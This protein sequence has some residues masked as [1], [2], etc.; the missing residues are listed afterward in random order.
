MRVA[1]FN[2][3]H[4]R[5]LT[6]DRVDPGRL[7]DAVRSLD[8]DVL[9]LQEVDRD[10]E[11]S[12]RADLTAVAA[13]A[14]GAVDYRFVA[15]LSGTPGATWTAAT[16]AEQPEQALYGVALLSRRRVH[17]WQVVRL[18]AAPGRI[19]YRFHGQRW[20][21]LVSDEPRV[22]V[23]AVLD[24]ADGPL[25]VATTH[26]SY[27]PGW[28]LVQLRR[29]RAALSA[30]GGPRILTGDLNMGP[31]PAQRV[32]GMRSAGTA[33]TFPGEAPTRQIDHVLLK[34]LPGATRVEARAMGLSDHQAL[35]V[36]LRPDPR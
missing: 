14:M 9:G 15:A 26:L 8:A 35:V 10:Q 34:G 1:T 33:L 16:G 31:G 19:P 28:N 17:S 18:P 6:D 27:L 13:Q 21:V 2:I 25:T 12:G 4:G 30:T 7:A 36:D 5:S 20:P 22:A 29:V 24:G 3:L 23:A 11:R 32:S